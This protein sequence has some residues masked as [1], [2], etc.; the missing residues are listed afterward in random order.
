MYF[1]NIPDHK[2]PT[3]NEELHF[4]QFNHHNIIF[5]VKPER[6]YCEQ[7][8]GFLSIKVVSSGEEWYQINNQEVAVRPGQF[9]I[10]NEGQDY[11]C[12]VDS[13][14][15]LKIQSVFFTKEFSS[16]V[17]RDV[18]S[19]E[20]DLLDIPFEH[21]QSLEFFQKLYKTDEIVT[22]KFDGLISLLNDGGYKAGL[23]DEHLIF[24]LRYMIGAHKKEV[25]RVKEVKALKPS[26]QKEIYKRLCVA[27]DFMHS[28]FADDMDLSQIGNSSCL[29]V[30][31]LVRQFK[32][33]FGSTPHQYLLQVRLRNARLLLRNSSL[34]VNEITWKCGFEN[35]SAFCRA[36]KTK[37]G[38]SPLHFR[39]DER[40]VEG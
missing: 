34:P 12:R 10:L 28:T 22:H 9:L 37:Y 20:D 19:E 33:V 27:K 35:V 8:K 40:L 30:P 25:K 39:A 1:T 16:S 3:F 14:H 32:S 7:H 36:F 17:F 5:N 6:A 2:S 18:L 11:T 31:Q 13:P 29:S 24:L 26:T 23:V 15:D 21:G 4:S 38:H